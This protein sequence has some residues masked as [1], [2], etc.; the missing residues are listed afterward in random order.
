LRR[1]RLAILGDSPCDLCTAACCKQ[2]GH[3]YAVLLEGEGE[4]RRFA[5]FAVDVPIEQSGGGVVLE[6]VLPYRNGRCAFLGEDDRCSIYEDRPMNCRRFQCISGY[7]GGGKWR[8]HSDFLRLNP[9]V[10]AMLEKLG[11]QVAG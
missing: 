3:G 10:L 11:S 8:R 1:V 9:G 7:A 5:P 4:R 6:R 2:N